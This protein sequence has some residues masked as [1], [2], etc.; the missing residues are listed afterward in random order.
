MLELVKYKHTPSVHLDR[1]IMD[2]LKLIKESCSLLNLNQAVAVVIRKAVEG[3]EDVEMAS[4]TL[5][6]RYRSIPRE[7]LPKRKK[8][9]TNRKILERQAL[10]NTVKSAQIILP[11]GRVPLPIV[12]HAESIDSQHIQG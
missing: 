11:N 9:A 3:M 12:K 2:D 8:R 7:L 6:P 5:A 1:R 10:E 4:R